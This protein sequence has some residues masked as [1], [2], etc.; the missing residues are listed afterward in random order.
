MDQL[1]SLIRKSIIA[2]EKYTIYEVDMS[3]TSSSFYEFR[4][5][6]QG[7]TSEILMW[8]TVQIGTD[9]F[10]DQFK[11]LDNVLNNLLT[12]GVMPDIYPMYIS[13]E[14]EGEDGR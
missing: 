13:E 9:E 8:Q 1:L 14:K 12:H 7:E 2:S 3:Y 4:V 6:R 5:Y 10:D 11:A